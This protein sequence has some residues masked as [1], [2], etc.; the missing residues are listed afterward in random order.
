MLISWRSPVL[1]RSLYIRT[2]IYR[3]STLKKSSNERSSRTKP[4]SSFEVE[5][6]NR[7]FLART[8][9]LEPGIEIKQLDEIRKEYEQRYKERQATPS[10]MWTRRNYEIYLQSRGKPMNFENFTFDPIEL[11]K[12][13]LKVGDLVLSS[14]NP[15]ELS[16]C[17]SLPQS[18]SDPRFSFAT[19]KGEVFFAT[20]ST[21]RMR[22]PYTIPYNVSYL[23]T[24]EEKHLFDAIGKVKDSPN[25]TYILPISARLLAVSLPLADITKSAWEQLPITI[26][27]LKLLHRYL[28]NPLGTWQIPFFEL[29]KLVETLDLDQFYCGKDN[30]Y[31]YIKRHIKLGLG[32]TPKS[33]SGAVTLSTY[34][35]IQEQQS[36]KLWGKMH[37]NGATLFPISL[38]VLPFSSNHVKFEKIINDVQANNFRQ[39]D[40]FCDL[41]KIKDYDHIKLHYQPFLY[42][43]LDYVTN[44]IQDTGEIIAILSRILRNIEGYQDRDIT[45]DA[46]FDL[47]KEIDPKY[48]KCNPLL[49]NTD[50][51]LHNST[52]LMKS[53]KKLYSLAEENNVPLSDESQRHDF[54]RLPVYCIDSES[55]HEID[56]G[57][58]IEERGKDRYRLH[59]HIADPAS[60]FQE[61]QTVNNKNTGNSIR[62][63]ILSVAC[64]KAFT[65]YLPDV[66][67]PMLPE[68]YCKSIQLG[69]DGKKTKTISFSVD[70][71]FKQDK[72]NV[73]N[74]TFK[75]RLGLVQNFPKMTY[76]RVDSI[77]QESNNS[78]TRKDLYLLLSVSKLLR[79]QRIESNNAIMFGEGFNKGL[80]KIVEGEPHFTDQSETPSTILVS[81]IMI[82]AN[83]LTG[84]YFKQNNIP[85]IYRCYKNLLLESKA[86]V[87]YQNLQNKIKAGFIPNRSEITRIGSLLNS[88]FYST[89]PYSHS[90]IGSREYLTVTSPLRR[91]PDLL[92]H[93]Q[94][95][96]HI[97][98]LP[99]DFS[100]QDVNNM[101]WKIQSRADIIK[102]ASKEVSTYWT[103]R[104]FKDLID[105]KPDTKFEVMVTSFPNDGIVKCIFPDFENSVG[106]LKLKR[107]Q[108]YPIIGEIVQNCIITK[109]DCLDNTLELS[110]S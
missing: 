40:K 7:S 48:K 67:E 107:D 63:E 28:Q 42:L 110:V 98:N 9:D 35:A 55:A 81:E 39:I 25:E 10:K 69:Y 51:G 64:G 103:L 32:R 15:K 16:M 59:I 31:E 106:I 109:I 49:L 101:I 34:W 38:S 66:V 20:R 100:F 44:S 97:R 58:S 26:K 93:M 14:S 53:N 108:A 18:L 23:L 37:L 79:K 104:Y 87:E 12:S 80:V 27:K 76:D 5:S 85:G 11:N 29:I 89:I 70:L 8:R 96:K 77:L 54:G 30:K 46:C 57:I 13:P 90:M 33:I 65:T 71:N 88:S 86:F 74:D 2:T 91:F 17:V 19:M 61:I 83:T 72:I 75:V 36:F 84:A 52:P 50:F 21:V 56:D 95:H 43:L 22:M 102:R 62:S 45:R 92:N 1:L 4:L 6:I 41:I 60:L 3:Y 99:F 105:L 47:L 82:L 24:K 94:L 68:S 73:L 78:Q